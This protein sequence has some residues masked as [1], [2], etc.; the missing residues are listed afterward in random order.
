M[1]TEPS[2]P[3]PSQLLPL[4]GCASETLGSKWGPRLRKP[5]SQALACSHFNAFGGVPWLASGCGRDGRMAS[6][7]QQGPP[8]SHHSCAHSLSCH[9]HAILDSRSVMT[10]GAAKLYPRWTVLCLG[11][12]EQPG[13]SHCPNPY[14]PCPAWPAATRHRPPGAATFSPGRKE[15]RETRLRLLW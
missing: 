12:G 14:T 11:W 2:F 13:A 6:I 7:T 15:G 3:F 9:G 1:F 8:G 5:G 4:P 10:P